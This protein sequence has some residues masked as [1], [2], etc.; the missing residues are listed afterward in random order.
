[1]PLSRFHPVVAQWF[2]QRLGPPTAAQ[3][4]GW[5]A[6][7]SGR[8]TLIAAPTGSGKTLAAFLSAIDDLLQEGLAGPLPDETRIVYVSPLKALS[9]DIHRNLAEPR[10]D[11]GTMA[12]AMGLPPVRIT[13]A[14]RTGDTP[15]SERAA[16]IRTPPH[17][18]VTTPESLYLLL[19]AERSRAMLRT[20]RTVIVDEIHAV[21]GS[22]RGAHLALSLERLQ[23][24][25]QN[26]LQ[27]IGLSATQKPIAEV[28]RFLV[29]TR[30]VDA[31]G[32]ANCAIIDEG[33]RRAVDLAIEIP[34]APLEAVMSGETWQEVYDR[35][36]ALV[37]EH[38]TT[39]IFT[40][41]RRLAERVTRHLG[42]RVGADVVAAH[43]GSLAK[44]V[45]RDAEERLKGG[46][47]KALVATASLELGIDIGS[48]DLV[49]QIGSTRRISTFV[50]RVGRSGHSIRGTPKGRLFPLSRDDL[51]ECAALLRAVK[52]GELDRIVMHPKPLDVLAQHIVA[53]TAGEDW[54]VDELF[55]L[56]RGAYSYRELERREYDD[57]IAM[58]AGGFSTRR[59]RRGAMLH[60]DAVNGRVRGRR[61]ARLSA[62][63]SGGAIP[64]TAD[65]R[66][67]LEPEG[68]VVGTLNED[69]AIESL[70]GDIFQLG[71][72]S[73]R[74]MRVEQGVV[75]V[76][77]AR[78]QPPTIPFWL[79]EAPGR[80]DELSTAVSEL[81]RDV[82]ARLD[83]REAASAWLKSEAGLS[84]SA[85]QQIVE[86]LAEARR[87]LGALPTQDTLIME[88]F[89]DESGGMQLVL[90]SPFGSRMNRAW[91]LALRKRFCRQF[92]FELQAA[93]T[94]DAL[95]LSLGPQHSFP[96]EDV[97]RYLTPEGVRDI[98]V[99]ALL[100]APVFQTRW[101]W[102]LTI[103]LAV[104]RN[105]AGRKVP[106]QLQ[107]MLS[108]DLLAAVFPDAAA[109]LEN[110]PGDREVPDHPLVRQTMEDCLHEAMD[111]DALGGVL[112]R[113]RS[114][115]IA[116]IARDLPEPSPLAHEILN[117]RPYAFLDDAPLEERRAH[118]V[119]TRRAAEPSSAADLGALDPAAIERVREE[120]WP[121]PSNADEL[122]D[123]LM[124]S[125]FLTQGEGEV[126]VGGKPWTAYWREL[127]AS[128]RAGRAVVISDGVSRAF[129]IAVERLQEWR[130]IFDAFTLEPAS[131]EPPAGIKTSVERQEAI[132]EM[133]RGR[134]E[135]AGP[136]T[137][138]ALA[139]TLGITEAEVET[140]MLELES[141]GTVLRGSFT[142]GIDEREWCDRRLLA[143]IHRYTLN[144]LR[145]EIEPVSTADFM[146]FLFAWQR[147]ASEER[148][149]GLEGLG[150]V[151]ALL[152]GY[153]LAAG[154][155]EGDVLSAR[156]QDYDPRLLDTLCLTGRIAW[157]R[158]SPRQE[159]SV[160]FSSTLIRST[161]IAL[162]LREHTSAWLT[163]GTSAT[164]PT[165]SE[166]AS[167]V[168]NVLER[169]GA[170]FFQELVGGSG[171]LATQ[172][173]KALGELVS[174]G[175]ATADGFTGL[176][177]L[178][179]PSD[180]RKPFGS[181]ARRRHRTVSYGVETAGRW[182]LLRGTGT[183]EDSETT[184][185][186]VYQSAVEQQAW[187]LLRRYGVVCKRVLARETKLASWR[188]LLLCYRRLEARGEIRGGR[189]VSGLPGE[190]FA[191]PEA[192]A[193][194]RAIR[195][196][197]PSGELIGISAADPLN[198]AGILTPGERVSALATNRVVYRDG[199]AMAAREKGAVRP[200]AD[201]DSATA[202]EVERA[203]ARKRVT[204]VLRAYL[205]RAG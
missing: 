99:Q 159:E 95:L 40:N 161:P 183:R 131:L 42:E 170:S 157:G 61:G 122:H 15:S 30:Q 85:A 87:M 140:A 63:T 102:N 74:I 171:L 96:L 147:V 178:L 189:F 84:S 76:E 165:L 173:E 43:H 86:Y 88:R 104:P 66:V 103:S 133:L 146:R 113:I 39:L 27:R 10:R 160:R 46:K 93:A 175:A 36:A 205:G 164:M 62:I 141:Q 191:L 126:G 71:N 16:M 60:H 5:E 186:A 114:G 198:L 81:R 72:T 118:A 7:R 124:T 67:V 169:R 200:L 94:E 6:I 32:L 44:E 132:R 167:S 109:C 142:P 195:R 176:R 130:A 151:L 158:L 2:S 179:T 33:H 53:E 137:A 75:R 123:S 111:L 156:V 83:D 65:Y 138:R 108:D 143:R 17:I 188:D 119:Y 58:L 105:R 11:I 121:D 153:E 116:C 97:F 37:R 35:L 89:F 199:V 25:T 196:A 128:G 4:R 21:I 115:T 57:V 112:G 127:V 34:G 55:Q 101:R 24:L 172:V 190:Q 125:G 68:T 168:L 182:S 41:T 163:L 22:R 139:R 201:Y 78:G 150:G 154:A 181:A 70:A 73:W 120:A 80:S 98:L 19:T 91:G 31:D 174:L 144:R 69:F 152:D 106:P 155:W 180:K 50:Q 26:P 49:C 149:S 1:M 77:D 134:I 129:W 202:L 204:P 14:V 166:Y 110:I 177:A 82:E 203:L 107:R 56:A 117:A 52:T 162:F 100:D 148:A 197:D 185:T 64:D 38:S 45:R 48:V 187:V 12:Q 18:L 3:S 28:A 13:A 90:H 145:A 92:N 9:A 135:I 51:I 79:G 20:V 29:G 47:L 54:S 59:G 8:H 136:V 192:I 184:S 193:Q 23:H 194:L